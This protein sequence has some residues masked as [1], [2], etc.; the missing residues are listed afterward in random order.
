MKILLLLLTT[1]LLLSACTLGKNTTDTV[2]NDSVVQKKSDIGRVA[3]EGDQVAVDYVGRYTDGS[4]FD[5][6]I[7]SEAMKNPMYTGGN[8]R[9]YEPLVTTLQD[10]GGTIAGFWKGIIG[11]KVGESKK[12]TIAPEDAYGWEW[13]NNGESTVDKKI[14]DETL[15][16]TIKKSETLDVI[17]MQVPKA[18]L[19]Q[20]G[21]L[22]KV[23]DILTNERGVKAKVESIDDI[24]VSL[25]I[26]NS[27][28]PFSGKKIAVGT[29]ITFEDGNVGTI[30]KV[31]ADDI[32][33]KIKN[34]SNPFAGKKLVVGLEGMY[35]DSQKVKITKIE[36][37][38]VTIAI[39]TKNTHALA[40]KTLE[41]EL[42]LREIK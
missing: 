31:G 41:F 39:Q 33:L 42:T 40:G 3:K 35:K 6:S 30:T 29:K 1:G 19:E 25:S 22:P 8:G 15:I 9:T 16:R 27:K 21:Q 2:S 18:T 13:I 32:T 4:V 24:N 5:A 38:M 28:N 14:F 36:K 34:N 23:G 12:V 11:M 20:E 17:K 37:D 26:D 10:G 7:E